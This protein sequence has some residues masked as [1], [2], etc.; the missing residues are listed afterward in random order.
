MTNRAPKRGARRLGASSEGHQGAS[1]RSSGERSANERHLHPVVAI[2][3]ALR[4]LRPITRTGPRFD[5]GH[6]FGRAARG[7]AKIL[8]PR[9][10]RRPALL[11]SESRD[12]ILERQGD[13]ED[14]RIR[15]G[16]GYD[17]LLADKYQYD[18]DEVG[19][20]LSGRNVIDVQDGDKQ[21]EIIN[22]AGSD[23]CR[24]D[25]LAER[26]QSCKVMETPERVCDFTVGKCYELG[27]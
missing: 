16:G 9:H 24:T 14:D 12:I 1:W 15:G 7:A 2:F 18:R 27:N 5:L 21:D 8:L 6:G 3:A 22:P 4:G 25:N 19:T 10:P 20:A 13:Y 11:G 26:L 23:V 17:F